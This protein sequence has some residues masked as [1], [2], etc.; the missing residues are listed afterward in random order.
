MIREEA[1]TEAPQQSSV[2][3]RRSPVRDP[4]ETLAVRVASKLEERDFIGAVC[5]AS[6]E[7]SI[8]EP[9]KRTLQALVEK[10]P[11]TPIQL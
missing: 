9:N 4:L 5:L 6:S 2:K 7:D 10:T 3:Q 1:D 11:C 8:A